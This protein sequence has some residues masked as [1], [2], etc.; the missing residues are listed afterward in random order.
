MRC[1]GRPTASE[2]SCLWALVRVGMWSWWLAT[3]D[4][5][6]LAS[7]TGRIWPSCGLQPILTADPGYAKVGICSRVWCPAEQP[8]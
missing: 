2:G 7:E 8:W 6:G 3:G 4:A 5:C 1:S